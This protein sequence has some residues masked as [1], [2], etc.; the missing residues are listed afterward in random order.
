MKNYKKYTEAEWRKLKEEKNRVFFNA[1]LDQ[2]RY[3]LNKQIPV[4]P[5]GLYETPKTKDILTKN[6]G[7]WLV[8]YVRQSGRK[9]I[10]IKN[11]GK[12]LRKIMRKYAIFLR[13]VGVDDPN[14]MLFYMLDFATYHLSF[15]KG[16]YVKKKNE[17]KYRYYN[18]LDIILHKT[19]EM[20][21]DIIK[22]V[23]AKNIEDLDLS[24]FKDK[25]KVKAPELVD[26]V[27]KKQIKAKKI[28]II[29]QDQTKELYERIENLYNPELSLK[30]NLENIKC[31]KKT[32]IKWK[33]QH[34]E[35]KEEKILRLYNP[36][37]GWQ[38]NAK[39]IGYSVNTIKKYINK[40]EKEKKEQENLFKEKEK[41]RTQI[42]KQLDENMVN[43][44]NEEKDKEPEKEYGMLD[45][46]DAFEA[47]FGK[48][49][50]EEIMRERERKINLGLL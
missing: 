17:T 39:V 47:F 13:A 14:A 45:D 30:E 50:M 38:K 28:S 6:D 23:L 9:Q 41:M 40:A 11:F 36:E 27:G 19:T 33:K 1:R 46:D 48:E 3:C 16:R 22:W 20:L 49:A 4:N 21:S 35:S 26:A 43:A 10:F 8:F 44:V 42:Q 24:D 7:S 5:R 2:M 25:R 29:R 31:D 15:F 37:I 32:L 34:T 18:G 12:D